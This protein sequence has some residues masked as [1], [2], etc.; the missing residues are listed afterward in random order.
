LPTWRQRITIATI[1]LLLAFTVIIVD[2]GRRTVAIE[3]VSVCAAR[4]GISVVRED[5][6]RWVDAAH[7]RG[8]SWEQGGRIVAGRFDCPAPPR[9]GFAQSFR[10]V[11]SRRR[12]S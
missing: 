11:F 7:A 8:A 3:R 2:H 9:Q 10:D 6:A 4:H 1:A 5:A 12:V